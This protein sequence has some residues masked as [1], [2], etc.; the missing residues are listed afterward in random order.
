MF[1][2]I[3]LFAGIGGT[4]IGFESA[5]G[6]CVFSSEWDKYAQKTYEVNF[7]EIPFG[8]IRSI[9]AREIPDFEIL[10]A[11]F[12]CQPFSIAGVSKKLSLGR[13]HGFDDEHQGNLFFEIA[14]ILQ[15]KQPAA[16]MLENVKNLKSHDR[17]NTFR[18]ITQILGDLGYRVSTKV[19]DAKNYVP[20]H[21]E[22]I[23]IVGFRK[24]IVPEGFEF[25]FPH[26]ENKNYALSS[27][28]ENTVDDRYTLSNKL[29]KY[30]RD[31]AAKHKEKGNGFGYGIAELSGITRTLSARYYKDGSEI[32]LAQT[33][34]NPRRLTPR[35][36]ARLMGF[37][38]S[39]IIPVSDSQA[40]K[41]F[42]NSIVVP[43]V[44]AVA[45]N[46]VKVLEQYGTTESRTK[47]L[48]YVQN[49]GK[50]YFPRAGGKKIPE[51]KGVPVQTSLLKV[52]R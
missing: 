34:S 47:K 28:L 44:T 41:Q 30:L 19:I 39:Y 7:G 49:P 27:I 23:F 42:G 48:E 2:F 46:I 10:V 38:D 6:E 12:P 24:D 18:I 3:D 32:L 5:G 14:R 16:L 1:K 29:W 26:P 36:C 52:I 25:D 43:V 11:G 45:R 33:G 9:D 13:A 22:R 51:F 20:Q 17:G 15:E 31:Y 40:Y 35:E 4:R 37:P 50:K 21:R 8:D